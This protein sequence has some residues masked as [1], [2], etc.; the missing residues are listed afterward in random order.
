[1][2]PAPPSKRSPRADSGRPGRG[3]TPRPLSARGCAGQIHSCR[4]LVRPRLASAARTR[5]CGVARRRPGA[6]RAA[7]VAGGSDLATQARQFRPTVA[8]RVHP[9]G[10]R[11][12]VA[13]P[14]RPCNRVRRLRSHCKAADVAHTWVRA[15]RPPIR[16]GPSRSPVRVT[17]CPVEA[18]CKLW[19]TAATGALSHGL[20]ATAF[21]LKARRQPTGCGCEQLHH[22]KR[23]WDGRSGQGSRGKHDH[24]NPRAPSSRL[25]RPPRVRLRRVVCHRQT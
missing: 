25:Q 19:L 17:V 11:G 9:P 4:C 18:A 20:W 1:M 16:G 7:C 6:E 5:A 13:A 21:C 12:W 15:G 3:H 8:V 22:V 10:G 14:P 23:G 2:P 24:S